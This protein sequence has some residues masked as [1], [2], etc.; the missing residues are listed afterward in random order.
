MD[1]DVIIVN[2]TESIDLSC[3]TLNSL[4]IT[5]S[6]WY[7]ENSN[8]YEQF[9]HMDETT[10]EYRNVLRISDIDE[11]DNGSFECLIANA[12]GED[13]ITFEL[14]VQTAPKIDSIVKKSGDQD[15][16]IEE[17][18]WHL[19]D[20]ELILEC[21]VDG[22]PMPD[23][24][25]F[26]DSEELA[27]VRGKTSLNFKR[28][29]QSDSGNYKCFAENIL[30]TTSKGFRLDVNV[31][32]ASLTLAE[33]FVKVLENE[34]LFLDCDVRAEPPPAISWFINGN[35]TADDSRVKFEEDHKV[36][37]L[38]T[39]LSDSGEYSC[40]AEN[41]FGR[42]SVN[43]TVLVLGMPRILLPTDERK[44]AVVGKN[45]ELVC[46]ATGFPIVSDVEY[47]AFH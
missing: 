26:H 29:R 16:E 38:E 35:P 33:S 34:K 27:F 5:N 1:K 42:A 17:S 32:P 24:K 45:L 13:K 15:V 47:S 18:L 31:A 40:W 6:S 10:D 39:R 9:V 23:I 22:F 46:D 25:W 36:L 41:E 44:K 28:I 19:E 12:L 8:N 7:N 43:F 11:L 3:D 37:T 30:G 21:V 14:L 2:E 20:Q 4:P